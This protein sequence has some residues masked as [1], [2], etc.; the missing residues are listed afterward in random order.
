M[1][2]DAGWQDAALE[3]GADAPTETLPRTPPDPL[4]ERIDHI[5]YRGWSVTVQGW[6]RLRSPDPS[7]RLSD[8]DPVGVI[9]RLPQHPRIGLA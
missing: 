4:A 3:G 9:L 8:H 6:H 7:H 2:R 5:L 1:L